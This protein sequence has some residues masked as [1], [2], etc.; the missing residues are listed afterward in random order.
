[1]A[2]ESYAASALYTTL[3]SLSGALSRIRRA[4]DRSEDP[5]IIFLERELEKHVE[6]N[7]H[8]CDSLRGIRERWLGDFAASEHE[9]WCAVRRLVARNILFGAQRAGVAVFGRR[10]MP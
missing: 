7:P 5:W 4:S 8:S 2:T 6:R 10:P 9:V 3:A 1:F